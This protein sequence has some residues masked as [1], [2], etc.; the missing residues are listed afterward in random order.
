MTFLTGLLMAIA[1]SVPGVSG[2]T[3]AY[4]LKR[5]ELLFEHINNIF[6]RDFNKETLTFL[7]KLAIGWIIGFVSAIFVITSI[8]ESHIYQI[9]SLFLGFIVVSIL[10]VFRQE[11]SIL[12]FNLKHTLIT[13]AGTLAVIILVLFQNAQII[14]FSSDSITF[15]TYIYLFITG[16]V[17]I[18]AMLLPGISGSAVLMIFGVYFLIIDSI[19]EFLTLNFSVFPI[20]L[21]FGLGIITGAIFATKTINNLFKKHRSSMI[22]LILGLL[23]GSLFA[24]I[25]G[26]TS[27]EG[28]SLAPLS[29]SNASFIFFLIGI[30]LL[31]ALE[32]GVSKEN[33]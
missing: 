27:I 13:I 18:S 2:G 28:Q 7:G 23:V 16:A 31:A 15:T 26:P 4:I 21:V 30:G 25:N 11:R 32:F 17:A 20:L 14:S 10:I 19:K 24:I 3:I 22:H 8:F 29:F 6:N 9:S 5:Y 33:K 12:N 1:D